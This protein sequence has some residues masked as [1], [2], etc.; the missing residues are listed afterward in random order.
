MPNAQK[1]VGFDYDGALRRLGGDTELLRE[2]AQFFLEDSPGLLDQLRAALAEGDATT[3]ERSAHS[4]KGLA[5]NFGAQQA[6]DAAL[7]IESAAR[8]GKLP[9]AGRLRAGLEQ[10]IAALQGALKGFMA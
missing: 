6:V 1:K 3:A 10:E 9:E 8:D 2:V 4:L 7:A 5:A